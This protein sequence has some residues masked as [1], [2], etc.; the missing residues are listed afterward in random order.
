MAYIIVDE[1]N[2]G[3]DLPRF[4][5]LPHE[6]SRYFLQGR[7]SYF[8]KYIKPI[9]KIYKNAYAYG[10][11]R[12]EVDALFGLINAFNIQKPLKDWKENECIYKRWGINEEQVNHLEAI[13]EGITTLVSLLEPGNQTGI[14]PPPAVGSTYTNNT[15]ARSTDYAAWQFGGYTN[16]ASIGA[17]NTGVT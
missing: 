2:N 6:A 14:S 8:Y 1:I 3:K 5:D 9:H 16:T 4:S 13:R 10:K 7:R 12:K 17:V 15:P 11:F